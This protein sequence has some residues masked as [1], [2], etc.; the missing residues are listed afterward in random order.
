VL[1][2]RPVSF[3]PVSTTATTYNPRAAEANRVHGLRAF[4]K[5]SDLYGVGTWVAAWRFVDDCAIWSHAMCAAAATRS[6]AFPGRR[7]RTPAFRRGRV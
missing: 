1:L 3:S 7:I 4:E 5:P 2:D 6:N